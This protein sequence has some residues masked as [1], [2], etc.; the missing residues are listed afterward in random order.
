[1]GYSFNSHDRASYDPVLQ[2]LL[3]SRERRLILV[4]PNASELRDRIKG[5]YSHLEVEA[6]DKTLK[7]WA[8]DSFRF[9]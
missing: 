3:E 1:M 4:S 6:I 8:A 7:N 5:E 2:A 9:M